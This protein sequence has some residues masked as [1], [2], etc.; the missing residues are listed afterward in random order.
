MSTFKNFIIVDG[1]KALDILQPAVLKKTPPVASLDGH[2]VEIFKLDDDLILC[3]IEE[4]NLNYF[5]TITELLEPWI[6]KADKCMVLSLQSI[7]EFKSENLP[8][9]CVIRSIGKSHLNDVQL[10]EVPNFITGVAAGVGTFRKINE[11]PFS[12]F[13]IYVD[14]L[15]IVAI[16]TIL[17]FLQRLGVNYDKTVKL[18][19]LHLKSDLYM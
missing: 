4:N 14:I 3:A 11:L 6:T 13:V 18:H 9:S 12:C 2:K 5:A 10:L 7:S 15:D 16:Q 19:P 1:M 8:E 17:K